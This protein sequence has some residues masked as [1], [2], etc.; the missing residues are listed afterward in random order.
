MVISHVYILYIC[1]LQLKGFDYSF[2]AVHEDKL[3]GLLKK[4]PVPI[5]WDVVDIFSQRLERYDHLYTVHY[6]DPECK[7]EHRRCFGGD[8]IMGTQGMYICS[9][10]SL[11]Q[12][13]LASCINTVAMCCDT[14]ALT[15]THLHMYIG[16]TS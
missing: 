4:L 6:P 12:E 5:Y 8:V 15:F 13:P 7:G 16:R 11:P 10:L 1:W 2:V 14:I 3:Q 9:R